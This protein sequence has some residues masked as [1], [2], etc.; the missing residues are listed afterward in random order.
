M[1]VRDSDS[2]AGEDGLIRCICGFSDDDG[3]TVQC[4]KCN[5]WQH[6][7]CCA[8]DGDE[9][10]LPEVYECERCNTD[11]EAF[12][13][14]V[15]I[16]NL[17]KRRR[18]LTKREIE[19]RINEGNAQR[20][21]R[22]DRNPLENQRKRGLGGK[23]GYLERMILRIHRG[24]W[25]YLDINDKDSRSH[26]IAHSLLILRRFKDFIVPEDDEIE[27]P[28]LI[29]YSEEKNCVSELD[30]EHGLLMPSQFSREMDGILSG[31]TKSDG[32]SL[33]MANGRTFENVY[34]A[35]HFISRT[36][37]MISRYLMWIFLLLASIG[38]LI[39]KLRIR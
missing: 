38:F 32:T 33:E 37:F 17:I 25:N 39:R 35:Q 11:P 12:N 14:L 5:V 10:S 23:V 27:P 15:F 7:A 8:A 4:E 34:Q 19:D 24:G 3:F 28:Q 16:N 2:S 22:L 18:N 21:H 13:V 26:R 1:S 9:K 29:K 31:I 6:I 30:V 36:D 20:N